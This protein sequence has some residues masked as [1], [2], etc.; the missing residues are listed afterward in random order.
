[1]SRAR[2]ATRLWLIQRG[3]AVVLGPLVA[4]HLVGMILAVRGGLSATEILDRTAGNVWFAVG[5]GVLVLLAGVHGALGLRNVLADVPDWRGRRLNTTAVLAGLVT[6][7][8]GGRAVWA[9]YH[10]SV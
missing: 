10:A 2:R 1:M 6:I 5:Y 3:S 8:L 7:G 4:A 9:L